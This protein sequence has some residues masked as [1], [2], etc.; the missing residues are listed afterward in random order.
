MDHVLEDGFVGG[1]SRRPAGDACIGEDD[2][3]LAKVFGEFCEELLAVLRNR[4][5]DAIAVRFRS[6]FGDRFIQRLLIA[7]RN[8]NFSALRDEETGRGQTNTTVARLDFLTI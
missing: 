1:A 3:K 5:V 8:C 2:A 7:A 4:N 6:Q